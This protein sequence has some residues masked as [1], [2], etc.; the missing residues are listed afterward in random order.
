MKKILYIFLILICSN[1]NSSEIVKEINFDTGVSYENCGVANAR[2][3]LYSDFN[4]E[5]LWFCPKKTEPDIYTGM[6]KNLSKSSDSFDHFSTVY[7]YDGVEYEDTIEIYDN[8]II[9]KWNGEEGVEYK[10]ISKGKSKENF[11]ETSGNDKNF[12]SLTSNYLKFNN[13]ENSVLDFDYLFDGGNDYNFYTCINGSC[14]G[15]LKNQFNGQ[16][17]YLKFI[18]N[19]NKI[20]VEIYEKYKSINKN[21]TKIIY[22]FFDTNTDKV[23]FIENDFISNCNDFENL[24]RNKSD[25]CN[26][27]NQKALNYSSDF[28]EYLNNFTFIANKEELSVDNNNKLN[29]YYNKFQTLLNDYKDKIERSIVE[30]A[31]TID[32]EKN[33]F[34]VERKEKENQ[35]KEKKYYAELDAN[36]KN[37]T[38]LFGIRILNEPKNYQISN[39]RKGEELSP[40]AGNTLTEIFEADYGQKLEFHFYD[41]EPPIKNNSFF[42]YKIRTTSLNGKE[43]ISSINAR[44]DCP[45]K[46]LQGCTEFNNQISNALYEKY[47]FVSDED[48]EIVDD[49]GNIYTLSLKMLLTKDGEFIIGGYN[50]LDADGIWMSLG[51]DWSLDTLIKKFEIDTDSKK[52]LDTNF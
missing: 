36:F 48:F 14:G 12:N 41:T 16:I 20:T 2:Y 31:S 4:H 13:L 42:N 10:L 38:K 21:R 22:D 45:L 51:I 26:N 52:K 27:M 50:Y 7:T 15:S 8:S 40:I 44:A 19:E 24:F 18:T 11:N 37:K 29:N 30:V 3:I 25:I 46:G 5:L 1:A 49:K 35:E 17:A 32:Q 33:R 43:I 6:W 47:G 23:E 9:V 34:E 39:K 28:D